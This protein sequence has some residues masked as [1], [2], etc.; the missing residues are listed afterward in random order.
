MNKLNRREAIR[1]AGFGLGS[2]LTGAAVQSAQ[3]AEAS[4]VNPAVAEGS[5]AWKYAI[6]DPDKV[7]RDA[8]EV[9]HVGHCMHATFTAIIQ[10]VGEALSKTDPLAAQ[11][12]LNFP[13]HMM[14]YGAS[15]VNGWGSLCGAVNAACAAIGLFCGS[16]KTAKALQDEIGN[17]YESAMLPEFMPEDAE[18]IPQTIAGSILCHVSSGKW[19]HVAK[20]RSDSPERSD[21]CARLSADL[22]KKTVELLNLNFKQLNVEESA[23]V[24]AYKR[25]EPTASCAKCHSKGGETSDVIGKMTCSEC[26]P[27]K[28]VDHHK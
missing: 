3:G 6:V 4:A 22:A 25:P 17:Y 20:A 26:H 8:Y 13:L 5:E 19:C 27:E 14:H 1:L 16:S 12:V 9:Y 21:R 15:G 10:N 28:T 7:A 23:P 24:V 11:A 2:M 18:P